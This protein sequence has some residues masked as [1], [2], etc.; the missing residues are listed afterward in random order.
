MSTLASKPS[1][2]LP[3]LCSLLPKPTFCCNDDAFCDTQLGLLLQKASGICWYQAF[4][5]AFYRGPGAWTTRILSMLDDYAAFITFITITFLVVTYITNSLYDPMS[6]EEDINRTERNF[7]PCC[8][9][10]TSLTKSSF[11]SHITSSATSSPRQSTFYGHTHVG[12]SK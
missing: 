1:I 3:K 10:G 7:P 12:K 8:S 2:L 11:T 4:K 5:T 9:S 6:L